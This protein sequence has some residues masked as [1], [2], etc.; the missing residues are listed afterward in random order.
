MW[1]SR[2]ALPAAERDTP[3][4]LD[5]S[6]T[7]HCAKRGE[8]IVFMGD[9]ITR[10]QWL[11][12]ATSFHRG[13][14]L[15]GAPRH[16][17][18]RHGR[19]D[20]NARARGA[21]TLTQCLAGAD[22]E[23]PSSVIEREWRHWM[24]FFNGTNERLLP[25][26]RC[27]CHR[28][29]ARPV[30]SKTVENRYYWTDDGALNLTFI[31]VLSLEMPVV[32]NWAPFA[33]LDEPHLR[34]AVHPTFAPHWSRN[35]TAAIEDVVRQLRPPPTVLIL[36]TGLWQEL[37]TDAYARELRAAAE[38]AAPRVI[39]KTT[40]RMRKG[41]PT[42]WMRTDL[43]ARRVFA[44]LYDSAYLTRH[45]AFSDFWDPRHFLPRVYNRVWPRPSPPPPPRPRSQPRLTARRRGS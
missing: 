45:A 32:G 17:N 31:N 21:R 20:P 2:T 3:C 4:Y 28:T 36:N 35:W 27:D 33:P 44:E 8:H 6:R 13:Y 23:F 1:R 25:S 40:T 9:S 34:E 7:A 39:W 12:L 19:C 41:G 26:G 37:P 22:S 30:G 18:M 42:R 15:P 29:Y 43:R 14:E 11:A 38:R 24:Q 10:Y 5:A 16:P